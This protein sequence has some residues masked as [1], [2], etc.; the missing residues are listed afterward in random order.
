MI[1]DFDGFEDY[2]TAG[3]DREHL[4]TGGDLAVVS[5]GR[6]G[7]NRLRCSNNGFGAR[8]IAAAP[9]TVAIG[10]YLEVASLAT[11]VY[12]FDFRDASRSHLTV[13]VNVDGSVTVMRSL[14]NGDF[15]YDGAFGYGGYLPTVL[16]SSAAGT[17]SA[18]TPFQIQVKVAIDNATGAVEV[19]VNGVAVLTLTNQDTQNAGSAT[20]T[21]I[22][23]GGAGATGYVYVDDLWLADDFLGDRRVDSH[24]PTSDGTNQDGTPSS[25]GDHFAMVDEASPDDDA[26][27][28]TLAAADDRE[29]YGV[30]AFKNTGASIDAVMVVLDAKK[31][32]AGAANLGAS[33]RAGAADYD[34]ASQGLTTAYARLKEVYATDP[35][36]GSPGT[37]WDEAAFNAAEFG[38]VKV[39]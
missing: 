12:L 35:A 7:G 39:L 26:T 3:I 9:A 38:A 37:V 30:E 10:A 15:A 32:D 18:G 2:A 16:G 17:V 1:Y 24:F 11:V 8:V 6:N 23:Y 33:V 31:T 20:V 21:H 5:G 27:Y 4:R 34:G 19:R 36:S 14:T 25:A 28:V 29:S 22:L 13:R